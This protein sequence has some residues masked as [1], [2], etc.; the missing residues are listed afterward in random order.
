M[1]M[2]DVRTYP[3]GKG[4][5]VA[6]EIANLLITLHPGDRIP[7]VNTLRTHLGVGTGTV[8]AALKEL[9]HL[10]LI[11]LDSRQN[12]GSFLI[13]QDLG[14]LWRLAGRRTVVG[15]LPLPNSREFQGLATGLGAQFEQLG[16]PLALT[17]AHGSQ[18]RCEALSDGRADFAVMSLST[19]NEHLGPQA[20]L[21]LVL[22]FEPGSYYASDSVVIMAHSPRTELP[23]QPLVGIDPDSDDHSVLTRC[24]FP[25]GLYTPVSYPLLPAAIAARTVDLAVWHRTALGL[26]LAD[27]HLF[28]W[29]LTQ[30]AAASCA[31]E[32]SPAA[33]LVR[34]DDPQVIA[35]MSRIDT[36][37]VA[38]VQQRVVGMEVLPMY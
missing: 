31:D 10:E 1:P 22:A 13:H 36:G 38:A 15:L 37:A 29:P 16:V 21:E 32:L 9:E 35:T 17:Y 25:R 33:I 26:S 19:A 30:A 23:R 2:T 7:N 24:E 12:R 18:R 11:V 8:Q 28:T 14:A 4:Y 34:A 27:Q 3:P 6:Q 20:Q 5:R